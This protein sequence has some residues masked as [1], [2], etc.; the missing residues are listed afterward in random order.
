MAADDLTS[1]R[2]HLSPFSHP[3]C[4]CHFPFSYYLALLC[5][6]S[7]AAADIVWVDAVYV[8]AAMAEI[9]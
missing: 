7:S 3:I 5:R 4:H 8:L 6:L 9:D 1:H 2:R